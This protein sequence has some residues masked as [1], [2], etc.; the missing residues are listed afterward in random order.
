MTKIAGTFCTT[1]VSCGSAPSTWNGV[2]LL[3]EK[4]YIIQVLLVHYT[5]ISQCKHITRSMCN[6]QSAQYDTASSSHTEA[7]F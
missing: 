3:R 7:T 2:Q 4:T 5:H 6:M 1:V